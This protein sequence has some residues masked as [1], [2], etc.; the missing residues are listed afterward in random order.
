MWNAKG[1]QYMKDDAAGGLH[2]MPVAKL[3]SSLSR[4]FQRSSK[5]LAVVLAAG[6]GKRIKSEKSKMLHEIWGVPTVERIRRAVVRGLAGANVTMVVGV[7]ADEVA[8]AMGVRPGM[9]YAYQKEQKGTGHA[10]QV[11]LKGRRL[12]G[13]RHCY[14]LPGDMGLLTAE[15]L[16]AFHRAFVRSKCDMM[17]LTGVFEG[18]PSENYYGRI[19]RAKGVTA[20]GKPSRNA[21]M[22]IEIKEHRDI[23]ALP[24]GYTVT[25][26]GERFSYAREELLAT[27]EFN[28]GV[29]AFR[30]KPLLKHLYRI[31]SDNAQNEVYLT[32]LIAMFNRAGL[33]VGAR[34]AADPVVVLGF[35]NKSVLKLMNTVARRQV[36]EQLKDTVSFDDPD[37]FFLADEVV[38]QILRL[39]RAGTPLDIRI[40]QGA[41]VGPEVRVNAGL[42]LQK[43]ATVS[44][45]VRFGRGVRI[46]RNSQLSTHPGQ[47]MVLGDNVEVMVGD[48]LSGVI[49]VG[50]GSRVEGGVRITGSDEHPVRI[51]T[52]VRIKGTTYIYGCSI[53]DGVLV[54]HC[55]LKCKHIR[56]VRREDGTVQ[57]VRFFVPLPEGMDSVRERR[58]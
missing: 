11:A 57:P 21:G 58:G 36:Y 46:G 37:D 45:G 43:G 31:R 53:E 49:T 30:M 26:R 29:Y 17:V 14:V 5:T 3:L 47:V 4:P 2:C 15:E 18:D 19:V 7:K 10:V 23:L 22:V 40:G 39:D 25:Y 55:F 50:A 1:G 33:Q 20:D 28:S 34:P 48:A 32:D 8:R 51:G 13:M 16:R 56:A 6:H 42:E 12:S 44:G 52:G 38:A 41:W 54:E 9:Q 24:A 27:R 35:N